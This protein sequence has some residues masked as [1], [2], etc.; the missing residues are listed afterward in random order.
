M[1]VYTLQKYFEKDYVD[2]ELPFFLS[3]L[4]KREDEVIEREL[5][6]KRMA[7]ETET[8]KR[9]A[10]QTEIDSLYKSKYPPA[11]LEEP[12]TKVEG[13]E[14]VAGKAKQEPMEL[15]IIE[16]A[17]PVLHL[18]SPVDINSIDFIASDWLEEWLIYNPLTDPP[19]IL[20]ETILCPHR[21]LKPPRKNDLGTLYKIIPSR[22]VTLLKTI[23]L[24]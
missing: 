1:L 14:A 2:P 16:I 19:P 23:I 6:Q 3:E 24:S 5:E 9:A 12:E 4:I 22:V 15:D 13:T 17:P 7:K 11:L 18:R 20:N 8:L 21:L 10:R